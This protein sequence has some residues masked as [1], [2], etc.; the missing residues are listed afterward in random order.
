MTHHDDAAAGMQG[1]IDAIRAIAVDGEDG[2]LAVLNKLSHAEALW[3]SATLVAALREYVA[4]RVG[5]K[6]HKVAR[7][8]LDAADRCEREDIVLTQVQLIL[9]ETEV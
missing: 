9:D 2:A 4:A 5:G 7:A 6:P 8:L 1:A 3:C